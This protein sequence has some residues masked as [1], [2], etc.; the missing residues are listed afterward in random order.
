M[1]LRTL[2]A[3]LIPFFLSATASAQIA[4]QEGIAGIFPSMHGVESVRSVGLGGSGVAHAGDPTAWNSNPATMAMARGIGANYMF[5]PLYTDVSSGAGDL[6]SAGVWFSI[7]Y[8]TAGLSYIKTDFGE[9]QQTFENGST[10]DSY[11]AYDHTMA[12]TAATNILP[13]F[14][15]G[16]TIKRVEFVLDRANEL[17]SAGSGTPS[18][19]S[20]E[21]SGIYADFGAMASSAGFLRGANL[22]DTAHFGVAIQDVGGRFTYKD[23]MQSERVAQWVRVGGS[24]ELELLGDANTSTLQGA[25][26]VEYLRML[27]PNDIQRN[28]E[29]GGIGLEATLLDIL[30]LRAGE[31][32]RPDDRGGFH[33]G[34]GLRLDLPRVGIDV[35][36]M[37]GVDYA[38]GSKM[39][40]G[41]FAGNREP[42]VFQIKAAYT[43]SLFE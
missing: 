18:T 28:T 40:E 21:A 17:D 31:R 33:F 5:G 41:W 12:L 39:G 37:V 42:N 4:S 35:P 10:G 8:L 38:R 24:Y 43:S 26:T 34:A 2:G 29:Y 6:T 30:S 22:R 11:R 16:V 23:I 15:F 9:F 32:F 19:Q 25:V 36:L 1:V 20:I 13:P 3:V 7:P 27:N 14:S